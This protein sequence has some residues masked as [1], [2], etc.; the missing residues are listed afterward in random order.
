[1]NCNWYVSL[2]I[3]YILALRS[4]LM[5]SEQQHGF[6]PGKSTTDALFA[7]RVLMEKYREGQKE[8]HCVF[9]DLEKAYDKKPR[10]E[11]WYCMR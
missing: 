9:V 10:E 7:L 11:V 3:A 6:M 4:E 2:D 1:M 8:L 5:F